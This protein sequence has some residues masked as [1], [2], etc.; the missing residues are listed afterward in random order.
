MSDGGHTRRRVLG[1]AGGLAGLVT[2]GGCGLFD[3]E[4][5]PAPAPDPLQPVLDEA[6]ALA[7]SYQRLAVT[8]PA[9]AAFATA[10]R[11]HAAELAKVIGT[12]LPSGSAAPSAATGAGDTVAALRQAELAAQKTAVAACKAAPAERAALIGSIAAARATHAEAL[13]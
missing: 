6:V 12:T 3:D 9:L 7:G 13:R 10:H 5:E 2:L 1:T 8:Q 11:A 4:P